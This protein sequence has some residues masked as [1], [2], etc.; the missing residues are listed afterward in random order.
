VD[1]S[2]SWPAAGRHGAVLG[3]VFG[4]SLA[5]IVEHAENSK[6]VA[7]FGRERAAVLAATSPSTTFSLP[8]DQS[9]GFGAWHRCL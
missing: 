2:P 8:G 4:V 1:R 9:P 7:G 5:L 6:A 3:A